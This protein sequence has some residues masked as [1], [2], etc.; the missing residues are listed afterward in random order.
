[1]RTQPNSEQAAPAPALHQGE[2][3]RFWRRG[4][5]LVW[6][7]AAALAGMLALVFALLAVVLW[8]G[9][10]VFW[11][12]QVAEVTL[13]DGTKFLGEEIRSAVNPDNGVTSVQFKTGNREQDP[14]RQDFCWI[15]Q[16]AI[17]EIDHPA[18]VYVL[19]RMEHGDFYGYVKRVA[20]PDVAPSSDAPP[21]ETLARAL[22]A[23]RRKSAEQIAPI[24][25]EL[26]AL[27]NRLQRTQGKL[28]RLQYEKDR[29]A[30][31]GE[32]PLPQ[33]PQTDLDRQIAELQAE[34]DRIKEQSDRLVDQQRQ[35]TAELRRNVVVM[36]NAAGKE[37]P[38]AL[39]DIV[40]AYN[41]NAMG[42]WAKSGHYLSKVGDLLWDNPRESNTEGGLFP[43]IFGTVMLIF[44]MAIT[45]FPLGVLAG[46]YLGEYAKEGFFVRLVRIA[47]NNLAGIPSIVYGVFGFGFFVY[48][49]GGLMDRCLFPEWV[50]ANTPTFGTGGILWASL[51]LGL[52]TVP[53]V[54]VSTEEA[55]RAIPRAT[56]EGSLALGATKFQTLLRVLVPMASP[57]MMTGFILAMARAAG[58]VAPLMITGVVKLAPQMPLDGAFPFIHPDRKFMHLGYHIYDLSCQSPNVE[59][60]KPMVFVTTLLLLLI[61]LAMSSVAIYLRNRMRKRYQVRTI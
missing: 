14:Q 16:D 42:F 24:A 17:R 11:P 7:T 49:V 61:V 18:G 43:A 47:V 60:N 38:I 22:D 13:T 27:S 50:A 59:A 56:R 55:L 10:G 31:G 58:E 15:K 30:A 57:G 34:R 45:C 54:I 3:G 19:E 8:N 35:R 41:P 51:T 1:M 39:A 37:T 33:G 40:R 44:L 36:A 26:F 48:G 4:E 46:V 29:A 53:V 25:A 2:R 6:T 20:G 9:L 12:G 28:L 52:L 5:P 32:I 21:A 23:V